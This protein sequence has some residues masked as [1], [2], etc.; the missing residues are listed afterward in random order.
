M[1]NQAG[2]ESD[3]HVTEPAATDHFWGNAP[4]DVE[5]V[6]PPH[7]DRDALVAQLDTCLNLGVLP[8]DISEALAFLMVAHLRSQGLFAAVHEIIEQ[9]LAALKQSPPERINDALQPPQHLAPID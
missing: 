9:S 7:P 2:G 3:T 4:N 1:R 8:Y 5:P 6:P